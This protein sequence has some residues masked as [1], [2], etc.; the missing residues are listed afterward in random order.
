MRLYRT[1]AAALWPVLPS[2]DSEDTRSKVMVLSFLASVFCLLSFNVHAPG[3]S[4]HFVIYARY[5]LD[6]T[7]TADM[8][9]RELGFPLL[10]LASGYFLTGS[11]LPLLVINAL[12]SFCMP[13][14]AY[15]IY[16][17]QN[18]WVAFATAV[19]L[20]ASLTPYLFLKFLHHDHLY[21]FCV[22]AMV[23]FTARHIATGDLRHYAY[24]LLASLGALTTRPLGALLPFVVLLAA[25]AAR[26]RLARILVIFTCVVVSF[27]GLYMAHRAT[28]INNV[29]SF[30]GAQLFFIPYIASQE[31]GI[32]ID[33][34]SVPALGEHWDELLQNTGPSVPRFLY[35]E[36]Q[37][38][39]PAPASRAEADAL[40]SAL[41]AKP[42]YNNFHN[43]Y[44]IVNN[45]KLFMT[46]YLQVFLRQPLRVLSA[47]W[48][49]F[50][51]YLWSPG[52]SF[53][54]V[55]SQI[56]REPFTFLPTMRSEMSA[57]DAAPLHAEALRQEI[58]LSGFPQ[59]PPMRGLKEYYRLL[60]NHY[61]W[62]NRPLLLLL[63]AGLC[64]SAATDKK[65][66]RFL[67]FLA[68]VCLAHALT[69]ALTVHPNSRYHVPT[70]LCLIIGGGGSV[71][72]LL[73]VWG[74]IR[75][76]GLNALR[77]LSQ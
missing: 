71:I 44:Y 19:G 31:C 64:A 57:W 60:H 29:G 72:A 61:A 75:R 10:L 33:K 4:H 30:Y 21:V 12:F 65:R 74:R 20:I 16:R 53:T 63:A 25:L 3:G 7:T 70:L 34:A 14:M 56:N 35:D 15:G 11:L 68:V 51:L 73:D 2:F 41:L 52:I 42:T 8:G 22:M 39:I 24:A 17:Q 27:T 77:A 6:G 1:L 40:L 69:V 67:A 54:P 50:R 23:Y 58:E 26:Q 9:Q 76:G 38:A 49:I 66:F 59:S 45:D 18:H 43:F 32:S 28:L 47:Y 5:L 13:L 36:G 62:L 48:M 37:P 46:M 55:F